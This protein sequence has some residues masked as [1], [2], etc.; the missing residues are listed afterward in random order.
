MAINYAALTIRE[1]ALLSD[2]SCNMVKTTLDNKVMQS[3]T[4]PANIAG[5]ISR[6]VCL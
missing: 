1:T 2:V 6:R 5:G 3:R 4:R